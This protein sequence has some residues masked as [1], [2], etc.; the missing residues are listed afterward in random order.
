M[1]LHNED[2]SKPFEDAHPICG[3]CHGA[4]HI[5]FTKPERWEHRK[6]IIRDQRAAAGLDDREENW[7]ED[8]IL[9]PIDINPLHQPSA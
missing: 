9:D 7:W 1:Q 8:L 5:R 2:Y 4:L 6:Q 3:R